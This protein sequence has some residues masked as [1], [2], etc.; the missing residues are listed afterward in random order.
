MDSYSRLVNKVL[1]EGSPTESR[2]GL[3]RESLN[4][5]FTFQAGTLVYRPKLAKVLGWMELCQLIG[6]VY[7][8][9]Q[10]IRVA[11]N[12]QVG[13]FTSQMAYGPRIVDHVSAIVAALHSDPLTRQAVLFIAK[14]S[15]GPTSKLPCTLTIQF[16]I[17]HSV[18]YVHVSMR[19][20]DL[21]R[22][23]PYDIVMFGGLTQVVA[24][25][26]NVKAGLVTVTA[27]STH[28][29]VKDEE[30]L[31]DPY[32]DKRAWF[33]LDLKDL[34]TYHAVVEYFKRETQN[35]WDKDEQHRMPYR[36]QCSDWEL[37]SN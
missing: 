11:P 26:L 35:P 16:I 30:L 32:S 20:W 2:F 27:G 17:R 21:I 14:R 37:T 29:Y 4:V 33:H 12:A 36:I 19:S 31:P 25:L 1:R 9:Q 10:I 34:K 7:D 23:L 13:L 15:D 22:G 8:P 18:L 6:G 24:H 3:T 28:V 5:Q